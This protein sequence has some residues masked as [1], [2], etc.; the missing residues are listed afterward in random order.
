MDCQQTTE[1]LIN[2]KDG[3]QNEL[4][5]LK[6]QFSDLKKVHNHV[7]EENKKLKKIAERKKDETT[8]NRGSKDSHDNNYDIGKCRCSFENDDKYKILEERYYKLLEEY[9]EY[10]K[11]TMQLSKMDD[12]SSEEENMLLIKE[13]IQ[14]LEKQ[15]KLQGAVSELDSELKEKD[16]CITKLIAEKKDVKVIIY[17]LGIYLEF[18]FFNVKIISIK[19]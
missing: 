18:N 10:R 6:L 3:F 16:K 19:C 1:K 17:I 12:R 7:L 13:N 5:E 4:S 8:L 2:L 15:I 14:L 9:D 11:N